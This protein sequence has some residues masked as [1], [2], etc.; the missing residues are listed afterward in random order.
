MQLLLRAF[1][2]LLVVCT[3]ARA[4]TLGTI[5][6]DYSANLS[7]ENFAKTSTV[8]AIGNGG[9]SFLDTLTFTLDE[10]A[11][12]TL[13]GESLNVT[14]LVLSPP[15]GF[16]LDATDPE[17]LLARG[18][19]GPGTY[20]TTLSGDVIG[21][22]PGTY[23]FIAMAMAVVPEPATWMLFLAGAAFIGVVVA[24]RQ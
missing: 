7:L 10:A 1:L 22:D 17:M 23:S 14:A 18:F 11:E 3:P 2:L 19:L 5:E 4:L 6:T 16:T 24:R 12:V 13:R 20:V 8:P 9:L 21:T 15:T